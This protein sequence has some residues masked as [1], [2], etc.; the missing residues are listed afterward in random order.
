MSPT[1]KRKLSKEKEQN[2]KFFSI[3]D[4]PPYIDDSIYENGSK[5]L[6]KSSKFFK[7][8]MDH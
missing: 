8:N 3:F 4:E 1:A 7:K 2:E 6:K 5:L